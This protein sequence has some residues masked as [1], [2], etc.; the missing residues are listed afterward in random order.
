MAGKVEYVSKASSWMDGCESRF[1]EC[2]QRNKK[3]GKNMKEKVKN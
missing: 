3:E 1:N 2:L